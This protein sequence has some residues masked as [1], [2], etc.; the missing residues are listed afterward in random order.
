MYNATSDSWTRFPEGLGQAREYLSSSSL[1]SG[2]VFFA[3]G[4]SSGAMK[5][6]ELVHRKRCLTFALLRSR[7]HPT[8]FCQCVPMMMLLAQRFALVE[9]THAL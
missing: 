7:L 8:T 1:P 5:R 4:A 9:L 3:G 2:L 6:L